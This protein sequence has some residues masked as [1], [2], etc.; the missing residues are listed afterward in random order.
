MN[1]ILNQLYKISDTIV[2]DKDLNTKVKS[3][4]YKIESNNEY[5]RKLWE[6]SPEVFKD[7]IKTKKRSKN[8]T[9]EHIKALQC[10][11]I[12][13]FPDKILYAIKD[14]DDFSEDIKTEINFHYKHVRSLFDSLKDYEH[15]S[16]TRHFVEC[17]K[18]KNAVLTKNRTSP[19]H[20]QYDPKYYH[21][22]DQVVFRDGDDINAIVIDIDHE[23]WSALELYCNPNI[24]TPNII[25]IDKM[26]D[27]ITDSPLTK[28]KMHLIYFIKPLYVGRKDIHQFYEE[29]K[30]KLNVL[31]DGD[32]NYVGISCKNFLNKS[33]YVSFC[34]T[35]ELYTMTSLSK[36]TT[37]FEMRLPDYYEKKKREVAFNSIQEYHAEKGH[38]NNC[39]FK[40]LFN[41]TI[42]NRAV[43]SKDQNKVT[44]LALKLNEKN[45][46]PLKVGEVRSIAKSVFKYLTIKY[47]NY[48]YYRSKKPGVTIVNIG[49][50]KSCI[51][52]TRVYLKNLK[53]L[54]NFIIK[55]PLKEGESRYAYC[56]RIYHLAK[57][58]LKENFIGKFWS[59]NTFYHTIVRNLFFMNNN[60]F[61]IYENLEEIPIYKRSLDLNKSYNELDEKC[62]LTLEWEDGI[63]LDIKKDVDILSEK[64]NLEEYYK[65]FELIP[66][67]VNISY[68]LTKIEN[69]IRFDDCLNK[70]QFFYESMLEKVVSLIQKQL[71][72]P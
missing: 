4:L 57:E 55:N 1:N 46:P 70:L 15:D 41:I 32:M 50:I 58:S 54:Y 16:R 5:Y 43:Y 29:L 47:N 39:L 60:K 59:F 68:K 53:L 72:V 52:K 34:C 21:L 63:N 3:E 37:F 65:D 6:K 36:Y 40:T 19:I 26:G 10:I 56:K 8:T 33:K 71:T 12:F 7:F 67:F 31:C 27:F 2:Q 38:R 66:L 9:E 51:K 18:I 35:K 17:L 30:Y 61:Q 14:R 24:P 25:V 42:K 20:S 13:K 62:K 64:K 22:W 45:D 69:H 23:K 44:E 28:R 48:D 49:A 11:N